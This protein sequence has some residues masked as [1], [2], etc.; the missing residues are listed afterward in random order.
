MV[1]S[2]NP[3]RLERH[4]APGIGSFT[5]AS[6][7][8]LRDEFNQA[9]HWVTNYFLN[10]I[11]GGAFNSP[12]K[13]WALNFLF[14]SRVAFHSYHAARDTTL[15]YLANSS[16]TRP[17]MRYYC[18]AIGS[19]ETTLLN[20]AICLRIVN[21]MNQQPVFVKGDGSVEERAY[22]LSNQVKH[23]AEGKIF[24]SD[25]T[26]PVWLTNNGLSSK[27]GE[28]EYGELGDLMRDLGKLSDE[29]QNPASMVAREQ[30]RRADGR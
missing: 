9:E 23:W 26:L 30:Q 22:N 19:W 15:A 2:W 3:K 18:D 16:P 11:T 29:V 24:D 20:W 10:T 6:I 5:A 7:P 13:Q 27:V 12:H 14:R 21:A 8:D 28:V 17:N 4:L 1:V 25:D